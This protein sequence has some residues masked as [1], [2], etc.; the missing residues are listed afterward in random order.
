VDGADVAAFCDTL[1]N[2]LNN[3]KLLL[4]E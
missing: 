2:Y 3:P 1:M 4:L